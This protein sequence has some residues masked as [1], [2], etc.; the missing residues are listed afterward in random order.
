MNHLIL[1][2]QQHFLPVGS[3]CSAS[4]LCVCVNGLQVEIWTNLTGLPVPVESGPNQL[5]AV[6]VRGHW[7]PTWYTELFTDTFTS[8]VFFEAALLNIFQLH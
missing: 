3:L 7:I 1:F 8:V 5:Q 6:S 4:C 2:L